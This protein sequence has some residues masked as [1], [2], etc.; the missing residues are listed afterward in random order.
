MYLWYNVYDKFNAAVYHFVTDIKQ[1]TIG[2]VFPCRVQFKGFF[3]ISIAFFFLILTA[4]EQSASNI[5]MLT[6]IALYSVIG[7]SMFLIPH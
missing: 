1:F 7:A 5:E 6:P 2:N 4:T 3:E